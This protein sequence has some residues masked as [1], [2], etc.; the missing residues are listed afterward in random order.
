MFH[1]AV[2]ALINRTCN[3]DLQ[4]I[5][6]HSYFHFLQLI[7]YN[8]T[9]HW[10]FVSFNLSE[11]L[12]FYKMK[13]YKISYREAKISNYQKVPDLLATI[14]LLGGGWQPPS[15]DAPAT[16]NMPLNLF[17]FNWIK[18]DP[19]RG[20]VFKTSEIIYSNSYKNVWR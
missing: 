11:Y 7:I 13:T 16:C 10:S 2:K 14:K 9:Y 6:K 20:I 3:S 15:G 5:Y 18:E 1:T 19:S 8:I 4:R 12:Y 17:F